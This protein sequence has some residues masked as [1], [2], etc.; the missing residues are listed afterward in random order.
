M[1]DLDYE[2]KLKRG[3]FA[4]ATDAKGPVVRQVKS[5]HIS[6]LNLSDKTRRAHDKMSVC[7]ESG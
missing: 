5:P 6:Q 3:L 1:V 7:D 4:S 2:D